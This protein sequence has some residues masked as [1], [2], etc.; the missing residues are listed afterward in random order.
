MSDFQVKPQTKQYY[1]TCVKCRGEI[2]QNAIKTKGAVPRCECCSATK[3][4]ARPVLRNGVW[5]KLCIQCEHQ[6][7]T[8]S[9]YIKLL[10]SNVKGSMV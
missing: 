7:I 5:K 2:A 3:M 4:G 10:Y 1:K 8:A 6:N 9:E